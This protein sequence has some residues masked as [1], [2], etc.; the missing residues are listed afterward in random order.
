MVFLIVLGPFKILKVFNQETKVTIEDQMVTT[1]IFTEKKPQK[2]PKISFLRPRML[3]NS[4]FDSFVP[5]QNFESVKPQKSSQLKIGWS[6]RMPRL[7]LYQF[8][9]LLGFFLG[10]YEV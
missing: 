3:K 4:V 6:P 5:I 8:W 2:R 9:G 7:A 10:R 1:L